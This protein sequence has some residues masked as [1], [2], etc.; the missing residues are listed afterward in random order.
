MIRIYKIKTPGKPVK[1]WTGD[2][3]HKE[4]RD[5]FELA[6]GMKPGDIRKFN[7]GTPRNPQWMGIQYVHPSQMTEKARRKV[8]GR[9]LRGE[10]RRL[11]IEEGLTLDEQTLAAQPWVAAQQ[12]ATMERWREKHPEEY[13]R[14]TRERKKRAKEKRVK[15]GRIDYS[16]YYNPKHLAKASGL[17]PAEIRKFLRKKKV[18]KRGGRYAFT[19]KE[20]LRIARA[21]KTHYAEMEE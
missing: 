7:R 6:R 21:A 1:N 12:L 16:K 4:R 5:V 19:K 3:L 2:R 11:F 17:T 15:E 13:E 8:V 20:A 18:G 10:A 9:G 14:K